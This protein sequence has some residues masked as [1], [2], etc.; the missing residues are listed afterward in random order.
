MEIKGTGFTLRKWQTKDASSLQ[1]HADNVKIADCLLDRFPSPYTLKCAEE[2]ISM[3]I[4][5]EPVT[6]FAIVINGEPAGVIGL[7]FRTDVYRKTPVLGY[8]LSEQHWG[9]GVIPEAVKL[10]THYAFKN[11]DIIC[12]Q[13]MV[14][15]KNSKSM[16]VLE[17]AGFE[18]QGILKQS[19]IKNNEVYDEHVYA[20]YKR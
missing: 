5:D 4:N 14:L 1:K 8:W 12:I 2:F 20:A 19:V 11:L 7:D 17:K 3:K 15:S 9:K 10:V 16:R 13:A 18:K 6:N